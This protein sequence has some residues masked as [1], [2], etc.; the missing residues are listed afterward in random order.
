MH[1]AIANK[2]LM[3]VLVYMGMLGLVS[4]CQSTAQGNTTMTPA[5]IEQLFQHTKNVCFGR[6]VL[7]VPQ[8]AQVIFGDTNINLQPNAIRAN[9]AKETKQIAEEHLKKL[10]DEYRTF[11]L[12]S[13]KP[14][15]VAGSWFYSFYTSDS[16]AEG[17]SGFVTLLVPFGSDA[18]QYGRNFTD[19]QKLL[20]LFKNPSLIKEADDRGDPT[21]E[22]DAFNKLMVMVKN[23]RYRD[24]NEVPTEAGF[25]VS[26]GFIRDSSYSQREE[27]QFGLRFPSLPDVTFSVKS[28][29]FGSL[30]GENGWGILKRVQKQKSLSGSKYSGEFLRIGAAPLHTWQQGEEVLARVR[31]TGALEFTWSQVGSK[32]SIANPNNLTVKL[33]N[34]VEG[35]SAGSADSSSVS[36]EEAVALWDKLLSSF[37]FRVPVGEG[38]S[39]GA[40]AAVK[41]GSICPKTGFWRCPQF[42]KQ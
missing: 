31:G 41:P 24:D 5:K 38:S 14:G 39:T 11:Q 34:K 6:Y 4:S 28:E 35:D 13:H 27:V 9:R 25:C 29:N 1:E 18:F 7:T 12:L 23:T 20:K 36:D 3:K 40:G 8:E 21:S 26:H 17:G 42:E 15:P 22:Q 2:T 33:F 32:G 16:R 10:R 37:K 30:E 19:R